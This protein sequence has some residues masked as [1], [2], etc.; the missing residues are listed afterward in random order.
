VATKSLHIENARGLGASPRERLYRAAAA[1]AIPLTALVEL[2]ASC[3]L[4]C[5]HC[6]GTRQGAALEQELPTDRFVALM[7]ELAAEG[8]LSVALTGGEIGTRPDWADVAWAAKRARMTVS[9]MTNGTLFTADDVEAIRR[10]HVRRVCVSLYGASAEVHDFVTRV[11]GSFQRTLATVRALRA[12]GVTCRVSTVLMKAND[13]EHQAILRLA[14]ELGCAFLAGPNVFP[15]ADGRTDVMEQRV[16]VDFLRRFYSDAEVAPQCVEGR[17]ATS[18]LGPTRRSVENCGAGVVG[19][20]LSA[21][22]DV[23][24]CMGFEPSFG[25]ILHADFRAVWHGAAAQAHRSLMARPLAA[26]SACEI[27]AFCTQRCARI[28]KVEDGSPLGPSS[29]ACDV[30]RLLYDMHSEVVYAATAGIDANEG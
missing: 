26:C 11:E 22:G 14:R 28:A 6:Y 15:R 21:G 8:C 10:L 17:I 4:R 12:A 20:F 16:S 30:A 25:S 1:E 19:A 7:A 24:P 18:K 2:T 9:L 3:N 29:R 27:S 13:G 5:V 23:L